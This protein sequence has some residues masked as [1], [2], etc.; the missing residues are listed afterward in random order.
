MNATVTKKS[1]AQ[2]A[3][4]PSAMPTAQNLPAV[5]TVAKIKRGPNQIFT[6]NLKQTT[7]DRR[8]SKTDLLALATLCT[9]LAAEA[10][11]L[12]VAEAKKKL[13]TAEQIAKMEAAA[14]K[15]SAKVQA[16]KKLA[17]TA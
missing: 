2:V 8:L 16:M 12:A 4:A 3:A 14:A 5:V 10:E 6:E 15:A 9:S 11:A 13:P 1:T 17:A 7:A